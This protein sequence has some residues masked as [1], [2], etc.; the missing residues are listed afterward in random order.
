MIRKLRAIGVVLFLLA[1]AAPLAAQ[2]TR[3]HAFAGPPADG[4]DPYGSLIAR[5]TTLYGMT[6]NGGPSSGGV[7]FKI[8]A[9]G[10]GYQ[11][12]HSFTGG[13][14]DGAMPFGS[15]TLYNGK[16]YGL[17]YAGGTGDLGVVFRMNL[18]G[19]G[20]IVLHAFGSGA[21]NGF[22]PFGSLIFSG[23]KLYGMITYGGAN[24]QG[25]IFQMGPTGAGFKILHSFDTTAADG[26]YPRYGRLL[27][28]NSVL[29]GL[30]LY[31]GSANFGV[32]FKI[33]KTG[34]GYAVLHSFTGG[35]ADG[36]YPFG[37][38]ILGGGKLYGTTQ[39]GGVYDAGTI[40][41]INADGSGFTVLHAFNSS[42]NQGCSPEGDLIRVV[43]STLGTRFFGLTLDGGISNLGVVFSYKDN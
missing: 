25:A 13:A 29:Y 16:L 39:L 42:G 26:S 18:D 1:A 41:R 24:S 19:T 3:M 8:N 11:V 31:G 23:T 20:Y 2:Y 9:D 32:L 14:A 17:T 10:T 36:K 15:L 34:S 7:I 38:L 43:S 27:A 35:A 37:S 28:R 40:F 33:N 5:G 22:R 6:R 21:A 12:L 4:Q 30:T